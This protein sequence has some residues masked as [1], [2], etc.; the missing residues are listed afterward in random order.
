MRSRVKRKPFCSVR[1]CDRLTS[2]HGY[3]YTHYRQWRKTGKTRSIWPKRP[4]REGT[5][6]FGGLM[7]KADCALKLHRLADERG[8]SAQQVMVDILEHWSDENP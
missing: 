4:G 3:C 1:N 2:A 6:K 5:I 7:L 8:E